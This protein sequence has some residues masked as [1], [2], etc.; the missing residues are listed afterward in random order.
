MQSLEIL[1]LASNC[2]MNIEKKDII[3]E[4]DEEEKKSEST[5][6]E[7]IKGGDLKDEN[8]DNEKSKKILDDEDTC[9][10]NMIH[11]IKDNAGNVNIY[12]QYQKEYLT[13]NGVMTGEGTEFHDINF[14]G[15]MSP[16]FSKST[17]T[18]VENSSLLSQWITEHYYNMGVPYLLSCA[19]F[20]SMPYMWISK[21]AD[22]LFLLLHNGKDGLQKEIFGQQNI[23]EF[24]AEIYRD[25]VNLDTGKTQVDF[26]RFS[27]ES[28]PK[29]ILKCVWNE[30]PQIRDV[31]TNW[32]KDSMLS[33]RNS[34]FC[35]ANYMLGKLA[36]EDYY[37]FSH[38]IVKQLFFGKNILLDMGLAQIVLSLDKVEKY[39]ENFNKLLNNWSKEHKVH[40]LLTVILICL[41]KKNRRQN[42]ESAINIYLIEVFDC[43]MNNRENEFSCRVFDFFA[44][45]MRNFTF[46]RITIECLYRLAGHTKLKRE[47]CSLFLMLFSVDTLMARFGE[48]E[49]QE[50]I[51]IKLTYYSSNVRS[52]LCKLWQ[53]VWNSHYHRKGFYSELGDYFSRISESDRHNKIEQF[54]DAAFSYI[55]TSEYKKDIVKKI[56]IQCRRVKKYE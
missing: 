42:L 23:I 29:V 55:C 9:L 47:V 31:I 3:Y 7:K 2:E 50:A 18:I 43:I 37:Y 16:S 40:Y 35:R 45:G 36:K 24:G 44:V 48:Q 15:E 25:D 11:S 34:I 39:K 14:S 12:I 46:Y 20:Y 27:K 10:E 4:K 8:D 49:I 54:V 26:V 56:E 52:Q 1:N 38:Y 30:F 22:K 13:N 28:Y 51:F 53:L 5:E 33:K 21:E 19:V 41:E 17:S 32:L 6:T